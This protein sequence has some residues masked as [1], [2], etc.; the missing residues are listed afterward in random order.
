MRLTPGQDVYVSLRH[1]D[2]VVRLVVR[3]Q[4]PAHADPGAVTLCRKRRR[5]ALRLLGAVVDD[6]GGEWGIRDARPPQGGTKTW[7]VL[8]S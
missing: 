1:R 8:P 5:R 6:W 7:V 3:D 4:H 2:D